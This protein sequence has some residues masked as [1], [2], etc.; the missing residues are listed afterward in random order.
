MQ[1]V[2]RTPVHLSPG[3]HADSC[4]PEALAL[5]SRIHRITTKAF[6]YPNKPEEPSKARRHASARL[7]KGQAAKEGGESF[8]ASF[9][10]EGECNIESR[11]GLV[12]SMSDVKEKQIVQREGISDQGALGKR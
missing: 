2:S 1:C 5:C 11:I 12:V 6:S 10:Q 3:P 4:S 7:V 9:F 8:I